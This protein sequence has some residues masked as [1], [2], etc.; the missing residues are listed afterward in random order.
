MIE[1]LA[2]KFNNPKSITFTCSWNGRAVFDLT[3][4]FNQVVTEK[5]L[6][7]VIQELELSYEKVN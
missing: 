5:D 7:R 6:P 2:Y 4:Q 1:V 3:E